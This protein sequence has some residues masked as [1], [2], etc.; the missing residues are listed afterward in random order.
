MFC[1]PG[2]APKGD[3]LEAHARV[4]GESFHHLPM[5]GTTREV[6]NLVRLQTDTTLGDADAMP[7]TTVL[8]GILVDVLA[9]DGHVLV[10]GYTLSR[11]ITQWKGT[12]YFVLVNR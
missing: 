9:S 6:A 3:G 7:K 1:P 2:V 12:Q 5:L 10:H 8:V 11:K 4:A